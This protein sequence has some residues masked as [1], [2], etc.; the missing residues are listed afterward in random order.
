MLQITNLTSFKSGK[1]V[2][3]NLS[4]YLKDQEITGLF[5]PSGAGKTSLLRILS[6]NTKDYKGSVKINNREL[7]ELSGKEQAKETILFESSLRGLN[8]ES[9]LY[10]YILSS[11]LYNKKFLNPYNESDHITAEEAIDKFQLGQFRE[12]KLKT[13]SSSIIQA[14]GIARTLASQSSITMFDNPDN[15]LDIN[16][17][18]LFFRAI[19]K[20]TLNENNTV[21]IASGNINFLGNICERILIMDKGEIVQDNQPHEITADLLKSIFNTDLVMVKNVITGKNEFQL[22]EE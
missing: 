6:G 4:V 16:Q 10:D 19:K 22:I 20:H 12:R 3:K 13:L 21:I 17:T 9:T 5:G 14:A 11:R 1:E 18:K 2:I 7:S 8:E 15:F